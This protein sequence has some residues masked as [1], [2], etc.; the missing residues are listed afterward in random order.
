MESK[1]GTTKYRAILADN[2]RDYL[3]LL[4]C[5]LK[6]TGVFCIEDYAFD[7]RQAYEMTLE[8]RPDLLV[9][10]LIMPML[11]GFAVLEELNKARYNGNTK[12][13]MTSA[14]NL[15]FV[16]EKAENYNID[17]VLSKTF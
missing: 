10:D 5:F 13:V 14:V 15:D 9:L 2:N 12:I 8:G 3:R 17:Y 16:I 6:E 11:D 1:N 7:G 4:A